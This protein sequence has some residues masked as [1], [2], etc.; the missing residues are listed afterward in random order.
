MTIE[1]FA[2]D[3]TLVSIE[4]RLRCEKCGTRRKMD[5][6]PDWSEL[7][8]RPASQSVGWMKPPGPNGVY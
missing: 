4:C 3:V 5:V 7:T 2:D 6:L 8:A 1:G